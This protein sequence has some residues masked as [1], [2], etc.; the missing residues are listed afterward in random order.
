LP[1]YKEL[2]SEAF[3]GEY[4]RVQSAVLSQA[5]GYLRAKQTLGDL[6]PQ[7]TNWALSSVLGDDD[8]IDLVALYSSNPPISL[9][10]YRSVRIINRLRTRAW[11]GFDASKA[12]KGND[13]KEEEIVYIAETGTVYHKSRACT[14]IKLSIKSTSLTSVGDIRSKND[15]IYHKCEKC[16]SKAKGTVYITDYG[17]RYHSSLSCSGLKRTISA[18]PISQVGDKPAC[19]KCGG[20]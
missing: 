4:G 9:M 17:D 14:H 13:G 7:Y 2:T 18:V 6:Y 3:D 8:C 11:T 10:G 16:G 5:Y 1:P 12:S 20:S 15:S 19:S